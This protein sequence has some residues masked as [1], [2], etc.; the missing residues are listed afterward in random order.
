[1]IAVTGA[2]GLLGRYILEALHQNQIPAVG[3]TRHAQNLPPGFREASLQDPL[4]MEKALDGVTSVI[5]A[6]GL[7]S[8]RPRDEHALFQTNVAGTGRLV[9]TCLLAGVKKFIHVSS[10][11]VFPRHKDAVVTENTPVS[12]HRAG[13]SSF[14]GYSKYLAELEVYRGIEEG[15]DAVMVNPSVIL[16]PSKDSRSSSRIFEYVIKEKVFY[17]DAV[18]NYVD[19]RDVADAV[20]RLLNH[21]DVGG[22]YILNAGS[23]PY[24]DFFNMTAKQLNK[25]PPRLKVPY[26]LVRA[27]AAWEELTAGLLN[28]PPLI[29]R[30]MA[31]AL[32]K[33]VRYDA[34]KA[35]NQLDI[36]FRPLE[37]SVKWC[38]AYY[39][40]DVSA[41]Y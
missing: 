7:V 32:H 31:R 14:Y 29:T 24:I 18:L 37:E 10:V 20:L 5:H 22:R 25:N 13:F 12:G 23:V 15:L 9:N 41:K 35:Q 30:S 3:L 26:P 36:R 1:M 33:K 27:A 4:S 17:T 40:S 21:V 6:A 38:C 39:R 19:A 2:T 28:R 8:F 11:A 34:Q 16:A